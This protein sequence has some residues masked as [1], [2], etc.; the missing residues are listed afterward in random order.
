VEE[1]A[2]L[3]VPWT[4]LTYALQKAITFASTVALARLLVPADF[5]IVAL[6]LLVVA[7]V[8]HFR[9]LGLGGAL[10]VRQDLDE[11]GKG[12]ALTL[13]LAT[14]VGVTVLVVGLSPLLADVFDEPRLDGV[15]AALSAIVLLAGIGWF[16]ETVLQRELEFRKRFVG[17]T[18]Q[19][20]TYAGTAVLL[21]ALGAGVWSLV[22]GHLAG[23]VAYTATLLGLTPYRVR[24][25]FDR[26]EA[27]GLFVTGRGFL[28]QGLL[29]FTQ[30]NADFVAVGGA[31]G[32]RQLGFYSMA[33]R[34]GELPYLAIADPIAKV[35]FPGFSRMRHRGE[36]FRPAFLSGLRLVALATCPLGVVLS[37]TADPFTRAVFGSEWL[38]MI[39][40]LAVLGI[41]ASVRTVQVTVAWL[42][43]SAGHADL[44]GLI[45]AVVLLP[46]VPALF[47]AAEL[48][49]I[50]AVAWVMLGDIAFSLVLLSFFAARRL[51]VAASA[52]W[53]A[54]GP[55]ALA[56]VPTWAAAWA[57]A[58]VTDGT[59]AGVALAASAGAGAAAYLGAV[60]LLA[61]G[62]IPEAARQVARTLGRAS[63]ASEPVSPAPE[64][65]PAAP[66]GQ[67]S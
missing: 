33:Y 52:Q 57:V 29:G 2:V 42:L 44:M 34:I 38:P 67:R 62:L 50:T 13:M 8:G 41:W 23:T 16:Y 19:S 9:D 66:R 48:G 24:P 5:G 12:T 55:V 1:K 30:Q 26:D 27:R 40:P 25:A 31:L 53:R 65:V 43:N 54:V 39:G 59:P 7:L 45:S 46:L 22:A 56:C 47:V 32:A 49:G 28:A 6:G 60:S 51:G 20:L 63:G 64:T 11:R 10:I 35:T 18:V 3:G 17:L 15:L 21:A 36:D 37:A 61:P 58:Q 4:L 14:G